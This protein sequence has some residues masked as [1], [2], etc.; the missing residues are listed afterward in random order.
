MRT[1]LPI[2]AL[3]AV[4]GC[5]E[6]GFGLFGRGNAPDDS[7]T[8]GGVHGNEDVWP[9]R[10]GEYCNGEDDDDDGLIDEGF[11]DTDGDGVADCIDDTCLVSTSDPQE[12]GSD[13]TCA[14]NGGEPP[15]EPWRV[16]YGWT[17]RGVDW[18]PGVSNV[19]TPPLVGRIT[20][21]NGDGVIDEND[22]TDVAFIAF[23]TS[24]DDPDFGRIV[25]VDGATGYLHF[26][27]EDVLAVG[28]LALADVNGDA[29]LD[30]VTYDSDRKPVAYDNTGEMLWRASTRVEATLPQVTVADLDADGIVDVI[31]DALRVRGTD[32]TVLN[33]YAA[34]G[35]VG[36]RMP[37]VA[38]V[39]LDGVQEVIL[40]N[41]MFEADGTRAWIL[42][43]LVGSYG[44]WPAILEADD[45]P[46]AEIAMVADGRLVI[47]DHDGSV[48]VDVQS[49]NDHPGAPCVA[50]FDGDGEAEIAWASNNRFVVHDLD[51]T[52]VWARGVNDNSGLLATCSGFDFDGDGAMEILYSDNETVY[53]FDGRTG[54]PLVVD[55]GHASTTI[56]E[57]PTIA[58]IDD[59]G[60]AEILVASNNW[61][62][63]EGWSG[64]TVI[65]HFA[66]GWMPAD[67]HWHV[68]DYAVTNIDELGHVPAR[69][70]P[71]WQI[72][73]V[74]R[75]RPA[76]NELV[77]DLQPSIID[78]CFTGCL[79]DAVANVAVQIWNAGN[80]NTVTGVP[81]ALYTREGDRLELLQV[82]RLPRRIGGGWVSETLVFEVE[83]GRVASDGFVVRVDDDGTGYEAHPDECDEENNETSWNDSPCR[84]E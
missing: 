23:D 69:P 75:A 32:G 53:I 66:D 57:Y 44:H 59:D 71:S 7:D 55:P 5:S 27:V 83:V 45:D 74:Y 50:D 37:A 43:T 8:D 46:M 67:G 56:W 18:D 54:T 26:T 62:S 15:E 82:Q 22:P 65:E 79:D 78:V 33:G 72:Y 4:S 38:D 70:E 16:K 2:V 35:N 10:N 81:V 41:G 9:P 36:Y 24:G 60:A 42:P 11:P 30:L 25:V 34:S 51:G 12:I 76:R 28:G 17:W 64:V 20:D 58:D 14:P 13:P 49:G 1:L 47:L 80:D 68:H 63:F 52:E 39:D 73:N 61:N 3:L 31:A 77:V 40:G 48:R 19:I 6:T 21:D 29:R 84:A